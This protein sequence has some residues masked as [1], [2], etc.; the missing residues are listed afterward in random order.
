VQRGCASACVVLL[1]PA[2]SV[3]SRNPMAK[4]KNH[5]TKVLERT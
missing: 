2:M 5:P 4:Q 1:T 3:G